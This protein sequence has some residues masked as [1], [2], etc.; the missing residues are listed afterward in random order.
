MK[1]S[2]FTDSQIMDALKRVEGGLSAADI[3]RELGISTATPHKWR[4]KY[5]GIDTSMTARMKELESAWL[6]KMY[7]GERRKAEILTEFLTKKW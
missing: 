5:G 7:A 4:A 6:K 1:K 3:C 2:Q